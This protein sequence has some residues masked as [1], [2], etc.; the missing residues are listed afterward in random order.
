MQ[1]IVAHSMY[2]MAAGGFR[3]AAFIG[4]RT[5]DVYAR[6]AWEDIKRGLRVSA[7]SGN[8]KEEADGYLMAMG[9]ASSTTTSP[10]GRLWKLMEGG[11]YYGDVY[12]AHWVNTLHVQPLVDMGLLRNTMEVTYVTRAPAQNGVGDG[13]GIGIL[14][15]N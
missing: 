14:F 10:C 9:Q 4:P 6:K 2:L 1:Q 11:R 5:P 3:M 15:L 7:E 8:D 13:D 12:M